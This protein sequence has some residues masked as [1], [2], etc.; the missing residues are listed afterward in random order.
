M[1]VISF[2]F[3]TVPIRTIDLNKIVSLYPN[4]KEIMKNS[5]ISMYR[6][7]SISNLLLLRSTLCC[8]RFER[9][10]VSSMMYPWLCYRSFI[11]IKF[12]HFTPNIVCVCCLNCIFLNLT[13]IM[14]FMHC[15]RK[16]LS[17]NIGKRY[18]S[19]LIY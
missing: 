9:S 19:L 18:N 7:K 12:F 16:L 13:W 8:L 5:K 10:K 1:F 11:K 2:V 4:I 17:K 14:F 6:I 15:I 3:L